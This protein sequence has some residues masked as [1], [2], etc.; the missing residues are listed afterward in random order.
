MELIRIDRTR[1]QIK[2][3]E[4]ESFGKPKVVRGK[5]LSDIN[6]TKFDK[7]K[8]EYYNRGGFTYVFE[9]NIPVE[10]DTIDVEIKS[11]MNVDEDLK[12]RYFAGQSEE[13]KIEV[14]QIKEEYNL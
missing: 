6:Y 1:K 2:L 14:Q 11:K 9:N 13:Y 3:K 4:R 8:A 12:A 7:H 10:D 5:V